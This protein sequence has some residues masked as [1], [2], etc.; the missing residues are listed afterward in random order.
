MI[1]SIYLLGG[2]HLMDGLSW[3]YV[4]I[5]VV[6]VILSAFFSSTETAFASLNQFKIKIKADEGSKVNKLILKTYNHFDNTLVLVLIGNNL[7]AVAISTISAILFFAIFE[8]VNLDA[9]W[10]SLIS[11]A[12]MTIVVYIFGDMVPKMVAKAMP[13]QM[14]KNSIYLIMFFYYLLYPLVWFFS[15]ITKLV[16][17]IFK[18]NDLPT[19][20]EE[21]FTN[22]VEDIEEKGLIEDNESEIIYNSLDF[23]DTSVKEVLTKREKMFVID[24]KD[25]TKEKLNEAILSNKYSRIPIVYGSKDKVVGILHVK[26]Y[27]KAYLKNPNVPIL[28]VLQKPYFVNTKI[29]M[30]D[31][32]DGF[33]KNHTHIAIVRNNDKVIG[34]ITMEDVLE[35][36]V[37]KI[38]EPIEGKKK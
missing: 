38:A 34:L 15:L 37:G 8:K 14:A 22:I 35:E 36:L 19:M 26:T 13:E 33:K 31:M 11:T 24:M 3:L 2:K 27:I 16:N 6:L 30:D 20:T 23:T 9:T 5:I 32:V 4:G 28:S 1:K 18:T 10:I 21:D 25:L 29:K 7:V 12:I 17:K